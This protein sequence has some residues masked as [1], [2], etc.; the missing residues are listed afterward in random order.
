V[1]GSVVLELQVHK[2]ACTMIIGTFVISARLRRTICL[3]P[4]TPLETMHLEW[5][6][7]IARRGSP[8][9]PGGEGDL[10]CDG[11]E[12]VSSIIQRK[13]KTNRNEDIY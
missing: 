13:L 12:A 2:A 11:G 9:G 7:T 1:I 3:A 10:Q 4:L 8:G 6:E 5:G